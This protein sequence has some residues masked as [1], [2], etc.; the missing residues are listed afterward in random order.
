MVKTSCDK[1]LAGLGYPLAFSGFAI[2]NIFRFLNAFFGKTCQNHG[3]TGP[4]MPP[5]LAIH[6]RTSCGQFGDQV[7]KIR[8]FTKV[9]M[10][11]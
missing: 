10:L 5:I 8:F 11:V 3:R 1:K 9:S 6:K 7:T 2:Y 4:F